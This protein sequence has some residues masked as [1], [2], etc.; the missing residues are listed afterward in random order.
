MTR[1]TLVSAQA[2]ITPQSINAAAT[3]ARAIARLDARIDSTAGTFPNGSNDLCT[4]TSGPAE[5]VCRNNVVPH[6]LG[7]KSDPNHILAGT[8]F[9][10]VSRRPAREHREDIALS[11]YYRRLKELLEADK[12]RPLNRR[13]GAG[14]DLQRGERSPPGGASAEEGGADLTLETDYSKKYGLGWGR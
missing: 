2:V 7:L 11:I 4:T 14:C 3:I 12:R 5:T 8:S 10:G 13:H 9:S 1:A 6:F